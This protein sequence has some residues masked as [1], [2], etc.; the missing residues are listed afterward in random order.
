MDEQIRAILQRHAVL[1]VDASTLKED[2]SLYLAGMT[3]MA[4]VSVMLGLEESFDVEF[5]DHMLKRQVF[6]SIASIRAALL[7]LTHDHK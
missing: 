1:A 3:S 4:S 5:P 6:E 2:D 7:E